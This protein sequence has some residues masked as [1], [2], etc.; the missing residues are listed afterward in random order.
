M[1][2][3][4]QKIDQI[5]NALTESTDPKTGEQFAQKRHDGAKKIAETAQEKGGPAMLTYHHF[6]VKLPYYKK[7]AAG[8]LDFDQAEKDYKALCDQLC[9]TSLKKMTQTEF[10]KLVGKIEVLGELLIND[11]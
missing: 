8:N 9:N 4:I 7:A 10:Q 2:N 11:K 6:I 1:S 5:I 3:I